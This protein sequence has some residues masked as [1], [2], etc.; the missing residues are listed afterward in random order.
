[1]WNVTAGAF[2]YSCFFFLL[3]HSRCYEWDCPSPQTDH[4]VLQGEPFEQAV[5]D[6]GMPKMT[7]FFV[8][9]ILKVVCQ[10]IMLNLFIGMI[11]DNFSFITDEVSH[12]EDER[13]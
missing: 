9:M 13:W 4:R 3:D 11:L 1:M 6:C 5:S 12:V 10:N 8:W 2:R 7:T